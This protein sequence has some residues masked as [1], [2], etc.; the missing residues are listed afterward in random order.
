MINN[1]LKVFEGEKGLEIE[2]NDTFLMIKTLKLVNLEDILRIEKI[3]K[4]M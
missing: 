4:R 1:F 3:I 2:I